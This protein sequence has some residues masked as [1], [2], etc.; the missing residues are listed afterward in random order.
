MQVGPR[1]AGSLLLRG[2]C[3]RRPA[4]GRQS[5]RW[6]GRGLGRWRGVWWEQRWRW[7]SGCFASRVVS[8]VAADASRATAPLN[9]RKG[10]GWPAVTTARARPP[11]T[12]PPHTHTHPHITSTN[13]PPAPL[14]AY[15]AAARVGG[16]E[17]AGRCRP[18][19]QPALAARPLHKQWD[20]RHAC[21]RWAAY[22]YRWG[23]RRFDS[24]RGVC[25]REH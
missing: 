2:Q 15:R 12:P 16:G 10:A 8:G 17:P 13:A 7:G 21:A 5:A 23:L 9:G 14:A 3:A 11:N 20:I 22:G 18:A 24:G 25:L 19:H 4:A 1:S 6:G